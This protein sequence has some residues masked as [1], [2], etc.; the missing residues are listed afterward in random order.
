MRLTIFIISFLL[1][2][3][4]NISISFNANKRKESYMS[5]RSLKT[6]KIITNCVYKK[7]FCFVCRRLKGIIVSFSM[8][9]N[10][11]NDISE[12]FQED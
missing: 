2:S 4:T 12:A 7:L 8:L 3:E 11:R 9:E 5:R 1:L 6:V 10:E